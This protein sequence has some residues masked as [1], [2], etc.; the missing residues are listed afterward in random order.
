MAFD[1]DG[2]L[3]DLGATPEEDTALR[4]ALGK[5]ER[6]KVLEEGHL[7]QSD[8]SKKHS[9][10][11]KAQADL[12]SARGKLDEELAQWAALTVAE[13]DAA[14]KLRTDLEKAQQRVLTLTQRVE[15]VAT[16]AGL[17]PAKALEGIDQPPPPKK[18]EPPAVDLSKYVDRETYGSLSDYM[19]NLVTELP[20]LAAEHLEITG[21]R[22]DTR[23]LKEE[24]AK[25]AKVKGA[26]L[27]PRAIWEETEDI[28]DKRAAKDKATRDAEL[29]A[30]EAR[31]FER[32]RTEAA[33]P[34]P[35]SNGVRSPLLRTVDG[36]PH[37][38]V[39]KRPQPESA[40]QAAAAAF[41]SGK[42]RTQPEGA[43][44]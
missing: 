21:Q 28:G 2:F 24:I 7:R 42:Y 16:D 35:P 34:V 39:F 20:M 14:T 9:G 27:D 5:P 37:E 6:L 31:G 23:K 25:R 11:T 44:T 43:Q 26:N 1:L 30:A 13:K 4:A 22:L 40:V 41:R 8:F 36:K 19:F 15:R 12:E 32:A 3:K 29:A 17:D 10:L 33:L 38:S 18:E